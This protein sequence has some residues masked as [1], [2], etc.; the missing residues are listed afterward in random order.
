[1]DSEFQDRQAGGKAS[2][3]FEC[4]QWV[5]DS[6][7]PDIMNKASWKLL[8]PLVPYPGAKASCSISWGPMDKILVNLKVQNSGS[9]IV[10]MDIMV[11]REAAPGSEVH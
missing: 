1:M 3:G 2:L 8:D 7:I 6:L 9:W 4:R 11:I 10:M 5:L